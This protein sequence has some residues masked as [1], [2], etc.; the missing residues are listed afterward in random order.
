MKKYRI[1]Y[2]SGVY[3]LLHVGHLNLLER[4]KKYCDYLIVGVNND[5]YVR[6]IKKVSPI[7][8]EVDRLKIISA[9]KV[10]DEAYIID[11]PEIL[12]KKLAWDKFKFDCLFVGDD[13]KGTD[14]YIKA[15]K[16]L[17]ELN[18]KI[19]YLPYTKEV[20]TSL[21]KEKLSKK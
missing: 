20:S 15:E 12:D 11:I 9:L 7:I 19:E 2:A 1:G 6:Q 21:L 14:R 13:W 18:V 17:G 8:S 16:D 5:N 3:D 4:C 10:V